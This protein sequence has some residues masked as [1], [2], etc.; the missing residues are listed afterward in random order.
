M[1]VVD[2]GGEVYKII[3]NPQTVPTLSEWG[4]IILSLLLISVGTIGI[5]RKRAGLANEV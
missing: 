4:M 1:Y 2:L 5:I 3:P